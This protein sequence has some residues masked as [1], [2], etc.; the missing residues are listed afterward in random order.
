MRLLNTVSLM[1]REFV[2]DRTPAYAILSHTW[3]DEEVS[4]QEMQA[5][6]TD[7]LKKFGFKK[8][9][10][11]CIT[12]RR[13]GFEWG[14]ID[15]CCIDKTSS[16]ELSEAINSMYRWYR[17]SN[18]CFV[19]LSDVHSYPL[20]QDLTEFMSSRWFTRGWTLQELLAPTVVRF[21]NS[22]WC[23]LGSK[24]KLVDA[25]SRATGIETDGM[26]WAAGRKTSRKEDMAYC[27]LGLLDVNMPLLYGEGTKAFRRLQEQIINSVYDHTILAWGSTLTDTATAINTS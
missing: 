19:Y 23:G 22:T 5:P 24:Q 9:I 17:E 25:I 6:T 15:T 16:G 21:F 10:E 18:A 11:F 4:L 7:T 1:L 8:I 2:D 14:W 20:G 27:L 13:R 3:G 26:S 12:A